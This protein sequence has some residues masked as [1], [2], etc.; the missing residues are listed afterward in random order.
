MGDMADL[1]NDQ[2]E[3]G[4]SWVRNNETGERFVVDNIELMY[5]NVYK[6]PKYTVEEEYWGNE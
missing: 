5:T 1:L 3:R 6:E 4:Q 2:I